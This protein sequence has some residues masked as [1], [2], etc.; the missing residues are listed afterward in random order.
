MRFLLLH[1]WFNKGKGFRDRFRPEDG[2][3][4][5]AHPALH[6]GVNRVVEPY[7]LR[8]ILERN[9]VVIVVIKP[10]HGGWGRRGRSGLAALAHTHRR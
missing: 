6:A 3:E 9:I 7:R 1:L 2:H 5:V 8:S 4:Q 10:A